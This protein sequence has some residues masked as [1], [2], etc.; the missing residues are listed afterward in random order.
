MDW[1]TAPTGRSSVEIEDRKPKHPWILMFLVVLALVLVI[2]GIKACS[3]ARMM[4]AGQPEQRAT[5]SSMKA[6]YQEWRTTFDAVGSV[7]PVRGA[8]LSTEL[9]GMVESF[10]FQSGQDVPEGA[11]VAQLRVQSDQASLR[12]A[13]AQYQLARTNFERARQQAAVDMISKSDYDAAVANLDSARAQLEAQKAGVDKRS[14]RAPFAGRLGIIMA[15]IGQY[16]D[17]GQ[18]IV[19]L[20]ALDP[21]FVD[22]TMPQQAL[23]RVVPG[24]AVVTTVDAYP[25]VLFAGT[26]Q[27][28]DPKVDERTRNVSVRAAFQNPEKKLLPGMFT[29]IS[30]DVG[31]PQRYLTLPQTAVTY[32]PYGE[33]VYVIVPRGQENAPDPNAPKE[34]QRAAPP[35]D[36][37]AKGKSKDAE[38]K[39]DGTRVARQVFVAVGPSRGDQ[40]AIVKGLKEGDEIVTSGQLKLRNGMP[41]DVDNSVLPSFDADPKPEEQ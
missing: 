21:V 27:A 18:R 8:D 29:R 4:S 10:H 23:S 33:T 5:V 19:T 25:N 2:G 20:Q 36:D 32:N 38:A 12:A 17:A 31:E 24:Q 35:A 7:R 41:V 13:Q 14:I 28:I 6:Q 30:V 3:V 11:L 15:N 40:V 16:V 9:P 1:R 37:A 22:F 34:A 39:P 26:I